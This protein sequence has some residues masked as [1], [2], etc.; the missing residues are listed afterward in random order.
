VDADRRFHDEGRDEID[1]IS[2]PGKMGIT[3]EATINRRDYGVNYG[4]NSMLSD[5]VKIVLQIEAGKKKDA[6]KAE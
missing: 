3:A 6:P 5:D 4:T 2:V 1:Y